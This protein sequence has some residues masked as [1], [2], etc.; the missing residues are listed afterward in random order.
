MDKYKAGV[1]KPGVVISKPAGTRHL[2]DSAVVPLRPYSSWDTAPL[3]S[4]ASP[5]NVDVRSSQIYH[6]PMVPP[7]ACGNLTAVPARDGVSFETS[8]LVLFHHHETG[9]GSMMSTGYNKRWIPEPPP[10]EPELRAPPPNCPPL[11]TPK[12]SREIS[13]PRERRPAPPPVVAARGTPP[14][15]VPMPEEDTPVR[16]PG[17]PPNLVVNKDHGRSAD[18]VMLLQ[19]RLDAS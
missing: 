12:P 13:P 5:S 6:Q 14:E 19:R 16:P 8:N 3:H 2:H 11:K 17:E 15:C 1:C 10:R 7:P 4:A 9:G 18:V